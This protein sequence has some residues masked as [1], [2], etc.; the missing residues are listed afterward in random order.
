[1]RSSLVRGMVVAAA[2]W[3][4][5]ATTVAVPSVNAEPVGSDI[6]LD[7]APPTAIGAWHGWV[8]W[9]HYDGKTETLFVRR[10]HGETAIIAQPLPA[11]TFDL[12]LGSDGHGVPTV[13]LGVWFEGS[14]RSKLYALPADGSEAPRPLPVS[15]MQ[16]SLAGPGL[17][18]GRL[19][20]GYDP[21]KPWSAA[22]ARRGE[23][24]VVEGSLWLGSR[25]TRVVA[26]SADAISDTLPVPGGVAAVYRRI[27][28][29]SD[30]GHEDRVVLIRPRLAPR[31]MAREYQDGDMSGVG[32]RGP[33]GLDRAGRILSVSVAGDHETPSD[34]ERS[35]RLLTFSTR[36]GRSLAAGPPPL[37]FDF[38]LPVAPGCRSV[39]TRAA[40]TCC[41]P[42]PVRA[43]ARCAC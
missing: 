27:V 34:P 3:G 32:G 42:R 2:L 18:H 33:L 12:A 40:R 20:F 41:A 17:R 29:G 10:P 43:T 28:D 26:R 19:T 6:Q 7:D 38:L 31:L 30:V 24:R 35:R 5:V 15:R 37:P 1:M 22:E 21:R 13:V 23:Y 39:G 16:G 25:H 4:V 36:T 8:A 9:L 11:R 14:A